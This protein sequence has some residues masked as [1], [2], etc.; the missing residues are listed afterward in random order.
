M[1]AEICARTGLDDRDAT[2]LRFTN[3]AVFQLAGDRALVRIV[4]SRALRHRADKV[5]QF[6]TWFAECGAP[7]VRLLPG[8]EQP[9]RAGEH[10][11]TVWRLVPDGGDRPRGRDLGRLLRV[12][13]DLPPP[14]FAVPEWAP[15]D[16]VRRRVDDAEGLDDETR[17]LLLE[18]CERLDERLATLPTGLPR[19]L[20]HGDAHLGNVIVSAD[21]PVLCDFDSTCV[22]PR[23]WDLT[24]VAVGVGRFGESSETYQEMV[25][26]YGWDVTRWPGFAVL[27]EV[28]ELKLITS[29]LPIARSN[30]EVLPELLRRLDDFRRGDTSARWARYT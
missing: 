24:P 25:D 28:R 5:V 3:N 8:I 19:G 6:A 15:I 16:D 17:H 9:V 13:H 21:G 18:C 11:A 30:P 26:A 27:R 1:L 14:P 20:V 23:E 4:A 29:V 12:M 2:L 22:G 10:L 7:T